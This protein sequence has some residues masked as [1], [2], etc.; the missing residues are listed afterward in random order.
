M[1][2]TLPAF[3]PQSLIRDWGDGHSFRVADAQ[4][5][6]CIFGATGS[7]K[8]SGPGKNLAFGY[9]A[10]DF[11]GVV[12]CAKREERRQWEQWAKEA[13]RSD[14]LVIVDASGQHRFNF[15]DWEA[16][17]PGEGGGL[18]INV[19]ALLDEIA[20]S[21]ASSVGKAAS[22][23]GGGD[24]KFW[25]DALHLLLTNLVDLPLAAG[26][27]LSLPL[28]RS[29]VAS[30]PQNLAQ[31]NDEK[32]KKGV[33]AKILDEA[34]RT[35]MNGTPDARAD[36]EE[37]QNYWLQDFPALSENTRSIIS[38]TFSILVRSFITRPLRRLFSSDTNIKPE[39]T[40]DGRIILIDLPVQEFKLAGKVANLAWKYCFQTA[41]L[42]RM[43]PMQKD[44]YL[45]PVFLW[46][47]EAQYFVTRNDAE[48]QAVARS[49]GGCTVYLS[50]NRESYRR[51]LGNNDA[52]DSLLGNLQAKIFC[53]N[54]GETND[55]ASKILGE[56]WLTITSTNVGQQDGLQQNNQA[57][58]TS[59]SSSGVSRSEQR[60][61]FLE[62]AV[63]TT[64]KRGGE[65]HNFQVQA[66]VYNGGH[67][68]SSPGKEAFLPYKILTFNQR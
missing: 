25:E 13:G 33:C 5:G 34:D 54:S 60:R 45:R 27:A 15:L 7:G 24:S 62:A 32:W 66:V 57:K 65:Q 21:I 37:C 19:V 56:R 44:T 41:V 59:N 48:Y 12:L 67:L 47:D 11:G 2:K 16:S 29:I 55:W 42:R 51:V 20:S 23:S 46:A 38:L 18:T 6:V 4:T 10:A 40:F 63:F 1:N 22:G 9:L 64:L 43:Q 52:V 50:Q 17:R 49:A 31:I 26:L 58:T 35:T 30:A 61:H 36:F 39:D 14:D 68:F 3:H 28:M 53:Q 8:S